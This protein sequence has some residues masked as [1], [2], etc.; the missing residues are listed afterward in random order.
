ME[1]NEMAEDPLQE[2][3]QELFRIIKE[4]Q[5]N[6]HLSE[7]IVGAL[8]FAKAMLINSQLELMKDPPE[9]NPELNN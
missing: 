5:K 9:D 1:T 3:Y 4:W 8:E 7:I 6:D 2:L